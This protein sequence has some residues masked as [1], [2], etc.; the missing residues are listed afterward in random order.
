MKK[1]IKSALLAGCVL[2]FGATA[3]M[4][5]GHLEKAVKAR[6]AVMQLYAYN[7]G[8]LGAMAKGEAEYKRWPNTSRVKQRSK[9]HERDRPAQEQRYVS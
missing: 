6:Q 8:Q 1:I 5:D 4:A 9:A 3:T 2:T 7:L